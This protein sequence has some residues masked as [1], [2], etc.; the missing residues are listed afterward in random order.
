MQR[1]GGGGQSRR[2]G[3][4]GDECSR[5][6]RQESGGTQGHRV[7]FPGG[8]DRGPTD[9]RQNARRGPAP[10]PGGDEPRARARGP[11]GA[12]RAAPSGFGRRWLTSV[13]WL[14]AARLQPLPSS[15]RGLRPRVPV[16]TGHLLIN[17]PL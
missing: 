2:V 11:G 16:F 10:G 14:T 7:G 4:R 1:A 5:D 8:P 17:L 9:L 15:T 13:P 3:I 6:D 12:G